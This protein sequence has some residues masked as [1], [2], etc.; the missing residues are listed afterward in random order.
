MCSGENKTR[1]SLETGIRTESGIM[2]CISHV[3]TWEKLFQAAGTEAEKWESA[4][5]I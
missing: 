2:R 5:D 4:W 1:H 3:K